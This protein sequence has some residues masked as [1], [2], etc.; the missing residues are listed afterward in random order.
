MIPL[1]YIVSGSDAL[2]TAKTNTHR[3]T[4]KKYNDFTQFLNVNHQPKFKL[5][6]SDKF[7]TIGSCFARNVENQ[8]RTLGITLLSDLANVP[9]E[10]FELSG[11]D[12]TGYQNVYTPG[13]ILE[14]FKLV[15]QEDMYHSIVGNDNLYIDLLTSGLR[16]L[17]KDKVFKIRKSLIDSY[18]NSSQANIIVITL[19]YN[20]AWKYKPDNSWINRTPSTPFLRRYI[21]DF[22]FCTLTHDD[23]IK[24]LDQTIIK[25]KTISPNCK[26]V[27]SVSPV[28]LSSTFT[29][30]D[31]IVANQISKSTL[32]VAASH[33]QN[34]YNFVDY[35]PSYEMIINSRREFA[36]EA[37]NIHIK[38]EA[39]KLVMQNFFSS[40]LDI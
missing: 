35:F 38:Q 1:T 3:S 18:K 25:I 13:S 28:P 4:T 26:I 16:P 14:M 8:L 40:Y 15:D 23:V 30:R 22:E 7:F 9:G 21:E 11:V 19:G 12:R 33:M 32:L 36:F 24:Q 2:N 31:V 6:K 29:N 27:L 17:P 37:D 39:V 34:K 5:K 20:E 10:D